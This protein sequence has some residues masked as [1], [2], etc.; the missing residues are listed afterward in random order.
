MDFGILGPLMVRSEGAAVEIGAPKQRAL[1]I[2][3][4][5][6]LGHTV[7]V[8]RLIDDLWEEDPPPQAR[9]TLRSYV[10]SLRRLLE[11]AGEG[12]VIV[13]RGTGYGL[14][15]EPDAVEAVRFEKLVGG[16]RDAAGEGNPSGALARLDEAL[17]LWRGQALADVTGSAFATGERTRLEELC[18][19]AHEDRFEALLVLGRHREAVAALESFT[20]EA[21]LR[22][23]AQGQLM[24][25]LYR[26]GRPADALGAFRRYRETL[27]EELGLDPTPGLHQLAERILRQ[28]E[29]IPLAP[30]VTAAAVPA[31]GAP[32]TLPSRDRLLGRTHER[33]ELRT[34]VDR[35]RTGSGG[36]LLISGEPGIGKST[37]LEEL[38]RVAG[39]AG[40]QTRW[41]RCQE[42]RGAPAFWPWIQVLRDVAD[43]LDDDQLHALVAGPAEWVTHLVGNIATRLDMP[44]PV[45][46]GDLEAAR[47]QLYD[48]IAAFLLRV[49]EERALVLLL[50]D[51][52]W[53]DPPSLETLAFVSPLLGSA[54]VLIAATYRDVRA[55]WAHDLQATLA[56]VVREPSTLQLGLVGL[57]PGDVAD[58]VEQITGER[59]SA[60]E[61]DVFHQRTGGNPFFV[62]QLSQLVS[63]TQGRAGAETAIPSGISYV[64]ARRLS[65]LPD[66][67]RQLLE[68]ASVVGAEFDVR[69]VAAAM[70]I[71]VGEALDAAG[72]AAEYGLIDAVRGS[73]TGYRFVHALVRETIYE[74]LSPLRAARTHAQVAVALEE[75][76]RAPVTALADHFWHAAPMV[77]DDRPVRYLL[78]AADEALTVF[79]HEQA[80]TY[81]RR[82]LQLLLDREADPI[83]ELQVRIRLVQLLVGTRGWS[84]EAVKE[85]AEPARD[86]A[87]VAGSRPE[88]I[89]LWDALFVQYWTRGTT[90]IA[91]E[92]SEQ[93]RVEANK[94][95]HPA[96][97]AASRLAASELEVS[98]GG[99]AAQALDDA[100]E[101]V[102]QAEL[103]LEQS[104]DDVALNLRFQATTMV[105]FGWAVQGHNTAAMEAAR[106][107]IQLTQEGA[108]FWQAVAWMVA[109]FVAM[110]ID[111]PEFAAETNATAI[112]LA[113]EGGFPWVA[114]MASVSDSWAAARLGGDPAEHA[115]R[116]EDAIETLSQTGLVDGQAKR[117]LFTAETY[118]LAGDRAA[119][120]RC[121]KK[122]RAFAVINGEILPSAKLDRIEADM[123]GLVSS[124]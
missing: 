111:E 71:D 42:A 121:L 61:R 75:T 43:V 21:P 30:A 59:P 4:L 25:A 82:A 92:M 120:T 112:R 63:E 29:E 118:L 93:L 119:A 51:L 62:R 94:S 39:D 13:T 37:V 5:L 22:E 1:L 105:A 44:L 28:E 108:E 11:G 33:A 24:L 89:P 78:A 49:A 79:A 122:A 48:A 56:T 53:A 60:D 103:A 20:R 67:V 66:D 81:L 52:H 77:D 7:P 3:L 117:L 109:G 98:L 36:L 99:D 114:A 102:R 9:V 45:L 57:Q 58:L 84:S 113:D 27:V 6:R 104:A 41:G 65:L 83:A 101:A 54:P 12:P 123:A 116:M 8:D 73:A 68:S 40:L 14:Q 115:S 38:A 97:I 55:E 95:G 87:R 74:K 110:I 91:K 86:L 107:C 19:S 124:P 64:I 23:R 35:V 2:C 18:L 90:K 72:V 10:S 80:E 96:A 26:S 85:I 100:T 15:V 106:R 70:G 76:P 88:V 46:E 31:A 69:W 50:D 16:A 17:G 32:P 47:F 34:A